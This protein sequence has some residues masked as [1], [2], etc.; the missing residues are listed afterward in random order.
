MGRNESVLSE[1][2][3][4]ECG[5]PGFGFGGDSQ[6]V[7]R[8]RKGHGKGGDKHKRLYSQTCGKF[9]RTDFLDCDSCDKVG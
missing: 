7:S 8:G 9:F 3:C 4:L 6:G 2:K 1:R 5:E